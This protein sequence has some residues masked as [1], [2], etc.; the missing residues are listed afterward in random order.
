MIDSE[1]I[2]KLEEIHEDIK[3]HG[4]VLT[5][6]MKRLK[7]LHGAE[8]LKSLVRQSIREHLS[9]RQIGFVGDELPVSENDAVRLYLKG[10]PVARIIEA[11]QLKGAR[12]DQQLRELANTGSAATTQ[13][14]VQKLKLVLSQFDESESD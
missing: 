10:T 14:L 11:V 13:N 3:Q 8:R 5:V 2:G 7:T 1:F 4:D 6:P 12:G 9:Y